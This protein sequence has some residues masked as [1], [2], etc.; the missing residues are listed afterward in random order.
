[1]YSIVSRGEICNII[2]Y[3][4]FLFIQ[5]GI[6]I[7]HVSVDQIAKEM[8]KVT[9]RKHYTCACT[10]ILTSIVLP[11]PE[12]PCTNKPRGVSTPKWLYS[13]GCSSGS[14]TN[15]RTTGTTLRQQERTQ[16]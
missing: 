9:V 8:P 1:M 7:S 4:L 3:I 2:C 15:W 5:R 11:L 16:Q 10:P 6:N 14:S 13:S 12:A